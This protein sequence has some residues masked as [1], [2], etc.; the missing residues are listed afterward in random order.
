MALGL[1]ISPLMSRPAPD[2][3]DPS[4]AGATALDTMKMPTTDA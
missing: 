2:R 1:D 4:F 3:S